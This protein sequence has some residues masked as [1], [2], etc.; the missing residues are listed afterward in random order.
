[1]G[2]ALMCLGAHAMNPRAPAPRPAVVTGRPVA[3]NTGNGVVA[4]QPQGFVGKSYAWVKSNLMM[5]AGGVAAIGAAG[6]GAWYSF[7]K[8]KKATPPPPP[9][10]MFQKLKAKKGLALGAIGVAAGGA[11]IYFYWEQ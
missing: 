3:Y 1:M 6:V 8:M 2:I 7:T 11:G 9:P 10:T 5:V 4:D